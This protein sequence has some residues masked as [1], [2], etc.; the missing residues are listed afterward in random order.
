M[1]RKLY[2]VLLPVL[3]T[4]IVLAGC[5]VNAP[6]SDKLSEVEELYD[7]EQYQNAMNVARYNLQE[8][9][10]PGDMASITTVWKVQLLQGGKTI[11]YAQ[12]FYF[13]AKDRIVDT[14]PAVIPFMGKSL[15][16][17]PYNTVRLFSLYALAEFDDSLSTSYLARVFEPEYT[18][19]GKPSDVTEEFL[20]SEAITV[21][22]GRG[23]TGIYDEAVKLAENPDPEMQAKAVTALGAI[24]GE[25]AI[26]VL[27]ALSERAKSSK[28]GDWVSELADSTVARIKRGQ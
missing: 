22:S 12:Q 25:K 20:K 19:G 18:M 26:P 11:D 8:G 17:D 15:L 10:K 3:M 21:L 4:V 23:F 7:Q 13:Q 28:D 24:G 5:S 6:S 9:N 14:G 1:Y 27:E 2:E 16:K